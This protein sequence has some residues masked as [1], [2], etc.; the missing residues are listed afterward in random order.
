MSF[1]W[2]IT[3][4]LITLAGQVRE[5]S[6][7]GHAKELEKLQ[8]TWTITY[9]EVAGCNLT[10]DNL[11]KR[12][13]VA[14][15]RITFNADED[16]GKDAAKATITLDTTKSPK[17]IDLDFNEDVTGKSNGEVKFNLG[18]KI[19]GIYEVKDKSLMLCLS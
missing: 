15:D 8:G 16:Q 11:G 6:L 3:S 1:I 14:K 7:E 2:I 13:S 4:L 19:V 10:E 9:M 17:R 12:I 18:R 5:R